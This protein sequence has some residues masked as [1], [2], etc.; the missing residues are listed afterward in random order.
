MG[1]HERLDRFFREVQPQ[2]QAGEGHQHL[3]G[4][5]IVRF[6]AGGGLDFEQR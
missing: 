1:A 4:G 6:E 3:M 5:F 2:Q